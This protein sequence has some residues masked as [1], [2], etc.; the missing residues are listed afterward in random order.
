MSEDN[1]KIRENTTTPASQLSVNESSTSVVGIESKINLEINESES[2]DL[3]ATSTTMCDSEMVHNLETGAA[4]GS[5]LAPVS[6]TASLDSFDNSG[7]EGIGDIMDEPECSTTSVRE[8]MKMSDY[9]IPPPRPSTSPYNRMP[10]NVTCVDEYQLID[11]Q[12]EIKVAVIDEFPEMADEE[13]HDEADTLSPL[14]MDNHVYV[15]HYER[16][17]NSKNEI[18]DM[19]Q[20]DDE[21]DLEDLD[22]ELIDDEHD[23]HGTSVP[24]KSFMKHSD[25]KDSFSSIDSDVS[26]SYDQNK[27]NSPLEKSEQKLRQD[28][29][30]YRRQSLSDDNAK[31]SGCDFKNKSGSD[32]DQN[33]IDT[34]QPIEIPDDD[35][36]EKIVEQVEFYFSNDSLLKDAFLLKHVRRNKEG[37]V[38]LKLVSSFKRVRQLTKDWRVVGYAIKRKSK[39]IELNDIETKIR[40][41]DPLPLYDETTPSRTV[42]ATNLPFDKLTIEKV[43]DIFS[44]CGEIALVR[45]LRPGCPI[46][47]DVRQFVN[48]HPELQQNECALVEFTESYAARNAQKMDEII[49]F[50]LVLPKKKTGKKITN[51]TNMIENFKY[52]SESEIERSRGG[53]NIAHDINNRFKLKRNNSTGYMKTDL[54]QQPPQ[55]PHQQHHIYQYPT[56]PRKLSHGSNTDNFNNSYSPNYNNNYHNQTQYY[57]V[58]PRRMSNCAP[59]PQ[60]D[61][62][63]SNC[64]DGYSSCSD[65]ISRRPSMCS[66]VQRRLSN[67]SDVQHTTPQSPLSRRGSL[68]CSEHCSCSS[69]RMSAYSNDSFRRISHGSMG[70]YNRKFSTGSTHYTNDRKYSNASTANQSDTGS[71]RMSYDQ[72]FDRKISTGSMNYESP[73]RK[74]SSSFDPLRKLSSNTDYYI[75]GRK[76]STDSGYDRRMSFSSQTDNDAPITRSRNNSLICNNHSI[77]EALV[78]KPMG[79]DPDGH[80]GFGSRTRKVATHMG[81]NGTMIS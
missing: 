76:I 61:R 32:D 31:D 5:G 13:D 9:P 6:S 70:D 24:T 14:M 3:P 28:T 7:D 21:F 72:G 35:Y 11:L 66:D 12:P 43:S 36:C 48:K 58:P 50:E 60:S 42:V 67:C 79:P 51:M 81:P 1:N 80:K 15:D 59:L 45:I 23:N 53:E 71:R 46:P 77:A 75:N 55:H 2:M 69:R 17:K 52:N 63:Y 49:V 34:D 73:I 30:D 41:L 29:Y 37:Y 44:K 39:S 18:I 4:S 56:S 19:H 20:L 27:S 68:N 57:E 25:T 38:S 22:D 26:L 65:V 62:K 74:F 8:T 64:S 16:M 54:P 33:Q 40:R 78:R 47:S 10:L